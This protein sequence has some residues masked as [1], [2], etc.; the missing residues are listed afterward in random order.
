MNQFY[1]AYKVTNAYRKTRPLGEMDMNCID[2]NENMVFIY[3]FI[4]FLRLK[5]Y[6]FQHAKR[7]FTANEQNYDKIEIED[8]DFSNEIENISFHNEILKSSQ[9]KSTPKNYKICSKMNRKNLKRL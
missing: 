7:Q 1:D 6:F 5:F 2:F 9:K 3:I 4:F 8:F